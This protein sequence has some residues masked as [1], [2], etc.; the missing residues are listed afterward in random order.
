VKPVVAV[1]SEVGGQDT[2]AVSAEAGGDLVRVFSGV[3]EGVQVSD[4]RW[5]TDGGEV[6]GGC[7]LRIVGEAGG[8]IGAGEFGAVD[9]VDEALDVSGDVDGLVVERGE[10]VAGTA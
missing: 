10:E 1:W 8:V 2:D 9:L 3:G 6:G 7:A 4:G 5:R